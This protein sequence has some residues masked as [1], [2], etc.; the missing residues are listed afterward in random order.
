MGALTLPSAGSVYLDTSGFIYSVERVEPHRTLLEPMWRLAGAGQFTVV[1][2][3]LTLLETLVKP[4]RE[5]DAVLENLFRT[6]LQAGEVRLIPTTRAIW[7]RAASLRAAT[8]LKTP[9][10]LHAATALAEKSDLFITNDG[11]FRRVQDLPVVVL[12]DLTA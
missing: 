7:E 4:L 10:A 8:G 12:A 6:L 5:N 9:D 1:S 11:D 2:S 3:E